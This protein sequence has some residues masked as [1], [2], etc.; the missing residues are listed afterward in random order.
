METDVVVVGAGLSG[1]RCAVRLQELGR[2]VVLVEA[3]DDVGG[4]LRTD[5]IDGFLCDRGFALVNPGYPAVKAWVD[6]PAL[7]LC[8]FGAGVMVRTSSGLKIVADPRREPGLLLH[9]LRSGLLAPA[10]V[11]ALV[12]WL[13][14]ALANPRAVMAGKDSTVAES[15]DEAGFSGP[16]RHQVVDVF[17]SG[18]LAESHGLSSASFAKLLARAFALGSPGL[19][20]T[21][22]AAL[23]R[24]LAGRVAG[25]IRLGEVVQRIERA[26]QDAVVH[27]DS[28]EDIRARAV[29]AAAGPCGEPALTGSSAPATHGLVTWWFEADEE[30]SGYPL[31][32]IDG[33]RR[34]ASPGPVWNAAVVTAV[35]PSYAPP[36]RHLVQATTLLDR[37][38]GLAS[39][40]E[41]LAHLGEIYG[42]ATAA[43]R[44]VARYEIPVALPSVPPPL[45]TRRPV[46]LGGPMFV[47]GDHLDTASIQ[48][49]LVSGNRAAIAVAGY[50]D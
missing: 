11:A 3:S 42:C 46:H 14:P 27:T 34:G 48:G 9:T 47:C 18:V 5:H 8:S 10:D 29:V 45:A 2:S 36:H 50:L 17:L 20:A 7:E 15:F 24:Q 13:A 35:A 1:L 22:M 21:G 19:P 30:P 25:P 40:Q 23:P 37:P 26:G 12:R 44:T 41:V 16:L 38:D 39:E 33:R 32:A 49:A 4:R 31:I 43:W 28:G 6:L